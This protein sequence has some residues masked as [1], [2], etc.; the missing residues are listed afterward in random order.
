MK[1]SYEKSFTYQVE[2]KIESLPYCVILRSDVVEL[3]TERQVTY[4]L[5]NLIKQ[6]KIVRVGYGIYAK[7]KTSTLLPGEVLLRGTS[8]FAMMTREMLDRLNISW[9]QSEAE[10]EY[11]SGRSTQVPVRSILR[12]KQRFR[13]KISFKEMIFKYKKVA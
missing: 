4:A 3:G 1:T 6:K 2:Q 12:L 5:N 9:L 11:N 8:G 10:E 7:T 13:R